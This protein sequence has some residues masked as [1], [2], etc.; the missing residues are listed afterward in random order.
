ML[1]QIVPQLPPAAN[2]VGDYG[3]ALARQL[4]QEFGIATCFIVGDPNWN[5]ATNIEGFPIKKVNQRSAKAL[6]S[7]LSEIGNASANLLLQYVGYGYATRG[8]PIWLVDGLQQWLQ[9][10]NQ[11]RLITMF[12]EIYAAYYPIWSSA[13]WTEP[14]QK[15]LAAQLVKM[16]DQILTNKPAYGAVLRKLARNQ[17][18]E[19][20][21]LPVFSNVG[22][23]KKVPPL[24]ERKP[25][26]VVFGGSGNRLKVYEQSLP[27]LSR[28]C[29]ELGIKNIIDIGPPIQLPNAEAIDIPI[30]ALGQQ[31]AENISAVLQDSWA[32]FF[33]YP[34][35]FLTRSGAFA[36][37]CAHGVIPIGTSNYAW[38][39]EQDELEAGEHYWL[40][41][42]T[43]TNLNISTAEAIAKK[44]YTWY[45]NHSLTMQTQYFA[46]FL[47]IN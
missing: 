16:S 34:I 12:H 44:A 18:L 28:V 37:Y 5:G 41:D 6:L 11:R 7:V 2:G 1:I 21:I 8:C 39:K 26:L 27:T 29:Q 17:N 22:E 40:A 43:S 4:W 35:D 30:I 46:K 32:G 10:T 24:S 13:F 23:P 42:I 38:G 36:A 19:I 14:L 15:Y 31:P 25:Q 3:L 20:P 9:Q 33:N 45:Q 47:T